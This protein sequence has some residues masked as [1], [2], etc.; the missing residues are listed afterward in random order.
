MNYGTLSYTPK[1]GTPQQFMLRL[2]SMTLGRA[3]ENDIVLDD[4][5]VSRYHVR[6]LVTPD[7][8]WAVDLD[9]T[10]GTFLN[11]VRLQPNVRHPLRDSDTLRVGIFAV[12]YAAA[13]AAP[14]TPLTA[15]PTVVP[16]DVAAKLK[17]PTGALAPV[18]RLRGNGAPPRIKPGSRRFGYATSSYLEYLPP[19]YHE[20]DF[21]GRFLLI[22]ESLLD[23]LERTI[24]QRHHY[25]DPQLAPEALLPWLATWVDLVLNEKWPVERQRALVAAAAELYRWRGTKRG[26]R[27]YIRM[28]TGVEPLIIEA[29]DEQQHGGTSLPAHVFRVILDVADPSQIDRNVVEAIIE[30]EKPAHT[31][32][33]LEIRRSPAAAGTTA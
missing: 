25:F 2:G 27:D 29:V 10:N 11:N 15:Q 18:R 30:A 22:F 7:G 33:I 1:N 21:L 6:L 4:E 16:P 28:Y 5:S 32:Y 31:G 20:D 14:A 8:C 24:A 17:Q 23:P 12:R 3:P 13:P 9:S 26:L 19:C